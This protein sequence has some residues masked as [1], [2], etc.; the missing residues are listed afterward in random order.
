MAKAVKTGNIGEHSELLAVARIILD[1]YLELGVPDEVVQQAEK[2]KM[3]VFGVSRTPPIGTKFPGPKKKKVSVEEEVKVRDVYYS[4]GEDVLVMSEPSGV[5]R[6]LCSRTELSEAA[7]GLREQLVYWS[8]GKSKSE[9][10]AQRKADKAAGVKSKAKALQSENS[11]RILDLL[12]LSALRAKSG[13]KS[14]LYLT[15]ESAGRR[16]PQ[17]FSVKSQMGSKSCLVNHSG[18]TIFKYEVINTTLAGAGMLEER[19]I[20]NKAVAAK[21]PEAASTAKRGPATVIPALLS[22]PGLSIKYHSVVNATFRES[23][24]MIDARF[25]EALSM[26]ILQRF[27]TGESRI[28][29]LANDPDLKNFCISAGMSPRVAESYLTEKLKD[30]LRKFALGMQADT[31]WKDQAEVQGGWVLVIEDGKVV[32]YRFDN[33]DAFRAYLLKHTLIDTPSTKRVRK[34]TAKVG[35]VYEQDG[36]LFITLSLIVKFT[37]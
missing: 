7:H 19:F 35:R 4:S 26:V 25:P 14:D 15:I 24:E 13:A 30:L 11:Q 3:E 5:S 31:P 36:K 28:A 33:P 37:E 18:A 8:S 17:G 27:K 20:Y 6:R 10:S 2:P 9:R 22:E 23:L 21:R 1:G 29:T 16:I 34:N 32:G 12:G